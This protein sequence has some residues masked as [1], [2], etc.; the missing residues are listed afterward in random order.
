MIPEKGADTAYRALASID[1][2]I[3]KAK[4]D[5]GAVYTNDFVKKANAKYKA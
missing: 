2:E 4:V 3:A 1:A 5:L